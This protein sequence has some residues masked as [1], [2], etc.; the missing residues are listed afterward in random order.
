MLATRLKSV[1][2]DCSLSVCHSALKKKSY[3]NSIQKESPSVVYVSV[4]GILHSVHL[5]T[6]KFGFLPHHCKVDIFLCGLNQ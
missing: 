6:Q 5:Q 4:L 3:L 2:L 1:C